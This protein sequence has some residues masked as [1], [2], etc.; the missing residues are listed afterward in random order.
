MEGRPIST[1]PEVI[2]PVPDDVRTDSEIGRY[3][4]WL[5]E[6]RG[7][8]FDDYPALH[9]WSVEDLDGF[10]SSIWE[11][12][13]VRA[14]TPY[15]RVLGRRELPGARWFPGATLNYAEHAH[16]PL[17]DPT[18]KSRSSPTRRPAIRCS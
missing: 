14:H 2:R 18:T 17:A 6:H 1:G 3:L 13:G 16:R 8:A 4:S 10:W 15:E 11:F 5:A 9:R 7:L 12:Y